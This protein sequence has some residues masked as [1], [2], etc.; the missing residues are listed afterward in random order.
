MNWEALSA[1][2][3]LVSA[4]GVV[5]TLAYLARQIHVA[6]VA[7]ADANRLQRA[8]GVREISLAMAAN[9]PLQS[10]WDKAMGGNPARDVLARRLGLSRAEADRVVQVATYW[11]WLHWGQWASSNTPKDLAE[12]EHV[13]RAFY[14]LPAMRSVWEEAP[15]SGCSTP[16]SC[17]S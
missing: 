1:I 8:A 9:E 2:G 15:R 3:Q 6:N 13:V 10:A 11:Q 5:V 4:L 17:A 16:H 7:A 12:L 14:A